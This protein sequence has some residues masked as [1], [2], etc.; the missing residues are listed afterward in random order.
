MDFIEEAINSYKQV[1]NL[2][3]KFADAYL[4]LGLILEDSEKSD[5]ALSNLE[6]AIEIE[7]DNSVILNNL[8]ITLKSLER[9]DEAIKYFERAIEFAP[10]DSSIYYNLGITLRELNRTDDAI[11]NFDKA[12][13]LDPNNGELYF[14]L[15]ETYK[16]IKY[17]RKALFALEKAY[18]INPGIEFLLGSIVNTKMD[19]CLWDD[20][21]DNLNFLTRKISNNEEAVTPFP[22]LALMDD[23]KIQLK[24]IRGFLFVRHFH[25][26]AFGCLLGAHLGSWWKK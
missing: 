4:N 13:L 1:L 7:P 17:H 12:I 8:G 3:P 21:N 22:L 24:V 14:H 10:D 25:C 2:H 15:G 6:K 19:L 5:E 18:S 16:S 20:L 11:K 9:V 23:P 26:R